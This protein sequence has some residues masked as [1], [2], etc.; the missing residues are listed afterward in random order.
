[1]QI[2]GRQIRRCFGGGDEAVGLARADD[3][4]GQRT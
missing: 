3:A 2:A 4:V 1:M